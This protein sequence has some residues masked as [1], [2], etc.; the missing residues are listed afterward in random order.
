MSVT[1]DIAL[2]MLDRPVPRELLHVAQTTADFGDE[3]SG[4]GDEGAAP[5]VRR[6]A[7]ET[8]LAIELR[9]PVDDAARPHCAAPFRADD[10]PRRAVELPQVVQ[11]AS[12]LWVHRDQATAAVLGCAIAQRDVSS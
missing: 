1:V 11:R 3:P 10:R 9:E 6:T 8:D 5:R 7:L 12:Q 2:G 4:V